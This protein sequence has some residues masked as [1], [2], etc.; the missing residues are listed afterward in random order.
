MMVKSIIT[1]KI[2]KK[3]V[4]GLK[5]FFNSIILILIAKIMMNKI[6]FL[7]KKLKKKLMMSSLNKIVIR[8]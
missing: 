3:Y 5:L 6:N 1:K 7:W 2:V 8:N 4:I